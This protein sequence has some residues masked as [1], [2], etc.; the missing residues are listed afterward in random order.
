MMAA[1]L[2]AIAHDSGGPRADIVVPAPDGGRTGYL[3]STVDGY[4]DAM[5]LA[6]GGGPDCGETL[7]IRRRARESAKRFSDQVFA[8]SFK[9]ALIE[10]G[11]L[12]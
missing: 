10:S 6:L 8:D 5:H 7:L 2:V 3:A 4:A 9:R 1:G 11:I 12:R